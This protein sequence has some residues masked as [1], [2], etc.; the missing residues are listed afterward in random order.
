MPDDKNPSEQLGDALKR[1]R[2]KE[3]SDALTAAAQRE[4]AASR[5]STA[6]TF[7]GWRGPWVRGRGYQ[8]GN[9][10]SHEGSSWRA[11][12]DHDSSEPPSQMWEYVAKRGEKGDPGPRG[13]DGIGQAGP[14][15]PPGPGSELTIEDE[16]VV[17]GTATTLDF[18][19]A[20]VTAS[21]TGPNEALIT[22]AGGAPG[23]EYN[24]D[25]PMQDGDLGNFVLAVRN[26]TDAVTTDADGDFSQFSVDSA[27]RIKV[28]NFPADYPDAATTA[29]V[30]AVLAQLIAGIGVTVANFPATQPVSIADGSDVA[31]GATTDAAVTTDTTGTLSGKLRG[32]VKWAYER[33]PSSLGQK[34]MAAS[35]P[36]TLASDQ[37]PVPVTGTVAVTQPVRVQGTEADG[38]APAGDP[39][40][41]AGFDGTLTQRLFTDPTGLLGIFNKSVSTVQADGISNTTLLPANLAGSATGLRNFPLLWNGSTWDRTP[42]SSA[43]GAT[44]N[45]EL[46]AAAALA[47]N[48]ANPTVPAVGAFEMVWD[49][50]NW[51][52]TPGDTTNGADVDVTRLQHLLD[53]G[54]STTTAADFTGTAF[55]ALHYEGVQVWCFV[56]VSAAAT[57]DV[58]AEWSHDG[59]DWIGEVIGGSVIP[60]A[61][62]TVLQR[63][64]HYGRYFRVR[65]IITGGT[66]TTLKLQTIQ[67]PVAPQSYVQSTNFDIRNLDSS[68]DSVTIGAELPAGNEYI[69]RTD[70]YNGVIKDDAGT[71]STVKVA[72]LDM[73]TA[74]TTD[75][76]AAVAGKRIRVLR[77]TICH[78]EIPGTNNLVNFARGAGTTRVT[79]SAIHTAVAAAG[80]IKAD[81]CVEAPEGSFVFETGDGE[82]LRVTNS[83]A[84]DIS[85]SVT[86]IEVL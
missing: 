48:T 64:P 41:V 73:T 20:G 82:A 19:G 76:V 68:S 35:F 80:T 8:R 21:M 65:V 52:R 71:D 85:V 69:G 47:D 39:V 61:D 32:L 12:A 10:V 1:A 83:S 60:G 45:T 84:S 24:E 56:D 38:I 59:T 77:Y 37:S 13:S 18:A 72:H 42:G 7:T 6:P 86:Y 63:R 43:L 31:E 22:I 26:D 70:G 49:G 57:V 33:M 53:T 51:D 4:A 5:G 81:V 30:A 66:Y 62:A 50:S 14:Q 46:P 78:N 58:R 23:T 40:A 67:L 74:T 2:D 15:G 29:Q 44:V 28:G 55:D 27:G 36:V 11:L 3:L 75:I 34:L 54:N 17:Q 16:G 9:V 25:T 79:G